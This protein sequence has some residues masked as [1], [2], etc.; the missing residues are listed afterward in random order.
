MTEILTLLDVHQPYN[1]EERAM[2]TRMIEF[3]NKYPT[4]CFDRTLSVGHVTGSAWIVDESRGYA[5]LVHHR[6]LDR[7][8]Q[9]GGHCDGDPSVWQ[10][11]QREAWEE[12]GLR[13]T[14]LSKAI[15]DLDI[16]TIPA[17]GAEPEHLHYDVRF[18]FQADRSQPLVVTHESKDIRWVPL[19]E[20]ASLNDSPSIMRMVN[21]MRQNRFC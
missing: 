2:Q 19:S 7:W 12:T 15:Y 5:L 17:R 21:R 9:P 6:K 13:V 16:H 20:I 11:A 4:C 18:L 3:V 1:A 8:F 14:S 10:V